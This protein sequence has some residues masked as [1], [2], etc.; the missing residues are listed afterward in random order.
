MGAFVGIDLGTTNS[1]V[2]ALNAYG[3]PEVL[4]NPEGARLTP[5]VISFA[6]PTPVVGQEAKELAKL[7]Q[8]E[9]A[10]FFKPFMGNPQFRLTF[11]GKCYDA[12]DLS[13]LI[14]RKLKEDAEAFLGETVDRAVITVPAYFAEP[15]RAA[16]LA[17]G[18]AAGLEVLRIIN[19]PTAA[20]LAYGLQK[21]QA[22]ETVLI[23]DLGGGTFDVTVARITP[24]EIAVL[25]TAGDH[26]LGGKNW[27]DRIANHLC[28]KFAAD[29][30]ID[31]LDDPLMLNEVLVRAEQAKWALSERNATRVTLQIGSQRRTYELTRQEFEEL[32]FPLMERTRRLTEEALEQAGLDWKRL[33]GVLLVGGSTRMPMVRGYVSDMCGKPPRMGVNVDE[34]VALGAAI[35]AALETGTHAEDAMPRFTLSG[36]R[37][38]RDVMSHSLGTVAVSADGTRY[39]NDVVVPR[40]QPIPAANTRSY[41]HATHEGRNTRLE[42]YLTQGESERPLDCQILG[43]YVFNGIQPTQAEVMV[44]V[45]ISYDENGMVQV[46]AR[47]RD[48]DTPLAMTIEPV[49]EDL[50]WLDRPPIDVTERHQVEPLAIL[51]LIDVSSS[52]AGPPL[53]EAREAARSFLDQCDFTTTRVGLISYSDQV[54]LQTDLTDNVRK[55]EAGLARLEADGTTNLAGALELG[56]RKLATVPTGHVKYLVVLTDGYPDDPD[57]ALLEAA[58]AKGSGIEIVAIGTGEA[59]QAY[60]DR[61]A[62]TQAGS[63]FARKGELVR[64][65]GHIARV[66]AEG[67]RS[68]RK[69]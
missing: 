45:S 15:Q 27:D 25:S 6:G 49:P 41:L 13:A 2:A 22:D 61:I 8:E 59:D 38:I 30:G 48:C 36:A 23:Y 35:Q 58:H 14:L 53:D 67:G 57:N 37:V 28:E 34:A 68:L 60:L 54:V 31:P 29:T 52:M 11:H 5:S 47:Q 40:N 1:L 3:R 62:S 26:D 66:I 4:P 43:K 18:R 64:A 32:T 16:T 46:E 39:V 44:D 55:V 12:T 7:G 17:A 65:F 21:T 19:E 20:A 42:V 10:S 24:R 69:L 33:G 63:I 50:S 51:L 56:R 9:I